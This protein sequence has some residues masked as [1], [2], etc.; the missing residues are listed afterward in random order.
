M[1]F[2]MISH[3]FKVLDNLHMPRGVGRLA[4]GRPFLREM[5]S[6]ESQ[7]L[8]CMQKAIEIGTGV[9]SLELV[10]LHNHLTY[11][12]SCSV[13]SSPP[14]SYG[15]MKAIPSLFILLLSHH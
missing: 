14:R 8:A 2:H 4:E 9:A 10:G 5:L 11:M 1:R 3:D 6:D 13:L 12:L 15:L 7:A